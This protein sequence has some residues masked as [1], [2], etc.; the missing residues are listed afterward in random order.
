[1]DFAYKFYKKTKI[2]AKI[3]TDNKVSVK[4]FEKLKFKF[5]KEQQAFDEYVYEFDFNT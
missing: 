5:I 2:I 4:L 1:M 3:K